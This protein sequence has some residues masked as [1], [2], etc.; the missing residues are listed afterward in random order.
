M[1]LEIRAR[2]LGQP[3][4]R[5]SAGLA[6]AVT[7]LALVGIVLANFALANFALIGFALVGLALISCALI[8]LVH[9]GLARLRRSLPWE[10]APICAQIQRKTL[11][12][13]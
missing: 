12:K 6:D 11:Y 9:Q 10:V 8:R 13:K 3:V 4:A 1:L 2:G 5:I 7:S